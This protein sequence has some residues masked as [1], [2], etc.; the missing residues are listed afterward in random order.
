MPKAI[1]HLSKIEAKV[2]RNQKFNERGILMI[3]TVVAAIALMRYFQFL[4][5][6][7]PKMDAAD[8]ASCRRSCV[9]EEDKLLQG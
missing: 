3:W 1:D 4:R 5:M 7:I 8:K 9:R 6:E 2:S